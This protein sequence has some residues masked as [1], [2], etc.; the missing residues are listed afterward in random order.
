MNNCIQINELACLGRNRVFDVNQNNDFVRYSSLELVAHLI[1]SK[2][3]TG[4]T[5]ELGVHQAHFAA[6]I[7]QAFPEK[8]LYLFDTFCGFNQ[9]DVN[10]DLTTG[11]TSDSFMKLLNFTDTNENI[12]L[13]KM[14]YPEKCIFRKGY[15]PDT[16]QGIEE[17][18]CFISLDVD[19]YVPT[20]NGLDYFYP[21]LVKGGYIFVHDYN[22]GMIKGV[23]AAVDEFC[24][25]NCI[26]L[27]PLSDYGGTAV[28]IK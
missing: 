7:N 24:K 5:A 28:L 4:E 18:F 22:H 9:I 14:K 3:L 26:T 17:T 20:K 15:F 27:F 12:V 19:L 16:A 1:N 2:S 21:R 13:N 23:K 8:K 6:Y 11:Y 25:N 10:Y